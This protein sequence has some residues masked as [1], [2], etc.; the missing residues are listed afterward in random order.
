MFAPKVEQGG[1]LPYLIRT[2][3][4]EQVVVVSLVFQGLM[5]DDD[6]VAV[7]QVPEPSAPAVALGVD[8]ELVLAELRHVHARVL[9]HH[10]HVGPFF[11][12]CCVDKSAPDLVVHG[13]SPHGSRVLVRK[14]HLNEPQPVPEG[15]VSTEVGVRELTEQS[16]AALD[17]A[18]DSAHLTA[19]PSKSGA[20]Q[21]PKS[22]MGLVQAHTIRSFGTPFVGVSSVSR[23]NSTLGM[24]EGSGTDM[25]AL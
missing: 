23:M 2:V 5:N 25:M 19:Q 14:G 4:H 9:G 17:H 12:L 13:A 18:R 6:G 10:L 7:L 8:R 24:V 11:V 16:A 1:P 22:A 21:V 15:R 3:G 20:T